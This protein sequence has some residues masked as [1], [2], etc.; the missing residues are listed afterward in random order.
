MKLKELAQKLSINFQGNGE[1]EIKG[2]KDT[3][4]L[5]TSKPVKDYLYF[6][7]TKKILKKYPPPQL[8]NDTLVLTTTSL[9]ENFIDALIVD[10]EES[11]LIFI[12]LLKLYDTRTT[13]TYENRNSSFIS[14]KAQIGNNCNI[15]PMVTI[16]DGVK[17]GNNCKIYPGVVIEE[18]AIIGDNCILYPNSVIGTNCILGNY[19][20]LFGGAIIGA[21]GF[22]YHDQDG[23]RYA[24]PQI[25]NVILED[26][27]EIGAGSSIDRA[28][29]ESTIIGS[30]T[31]IDNQ[32]QIGHNCQ[33]GKFVFIAGNAG[34]SG[35]V[36]LEDR[37]IIAGQ[38]GLA[39]HVKVGEGAVV[40]AL[41][42]VNTDIQAKKIVFGIP[43]RPI[44]EFAKINGAIP[45][46]PEL[47]KRVRSLEEDNG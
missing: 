38:A 46:L 32:V 5:A 12:E 29:I 20:I 39:D 22:G 41:T 14:A 25:G 31:K 17:I 23:K 21:D 8:A 4:L 2:I 15:M 33:V 36:T 3:N 47:L 18:N 27:V 34:I 45:H 30:N 43:A 16:L 26:Y 7:E 13:A 40:M 9:K 6:V 19:C 44:K 28:T 42:G 1:L 11:R 35:S 10:N 24:V 37:V